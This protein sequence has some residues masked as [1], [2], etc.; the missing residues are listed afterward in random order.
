M[1]LD[2]MEIISPLLS[3]LFFSLLFFESLHFRV[4]AQL[5]R[6]PPSLLFSRPVPCLE[7]LKCSSTFFSS[8]LFSSLLFLSGD[9][10]EKG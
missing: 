5:K 6:E 8:L 3:P 1:K 4:E 9:G 2:V 10:A 7:I